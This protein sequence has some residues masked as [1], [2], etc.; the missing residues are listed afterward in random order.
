V[1]DSTQRT[2]SVEDELGP[3]SPELCLVDPELAR[4]ARAR[5]KVDDDLLRDLPKLAPA[6]PPPVLRAPDPDSAPARAS[7]RAVPPARLRAVR[8][9]SP[10]RTRP[11]LRLVV[12]GAALLVALPFL[13]SPEVRGAEPARF[14]SRSQ[15]ADP[16]KDSG[17]VLIVPDVCRLAYVFAKGRLQEAGFA[18]DVAGPVQGYAGN[19][20]SEQEPAPGTVVVDTGAPTVTL[21][22]AH[23]PEYT[24]RGHPDNQAPY[25][26]TTLEVAPLGT[27]FADVLAQSGNA[28][29]LN[30]CER[31]AS[32]DPTPLQHGL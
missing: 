9:R 31:G 18:W 16:S 4:V 26:G 5:L 17:G 6:P 12:A 27:T 28:P 24:P 10:V 8:E 22:L 15:I 30:R 20:V 11:L 29:V 7:L 13:P 32:G 14:Q 3:I 2:R 23:N 1:D 21:S 25:E 19:R